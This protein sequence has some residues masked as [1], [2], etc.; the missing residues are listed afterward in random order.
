MYV[1]PEIEICSLN[2]NDII[3]TSDPGDLPINGPVDWG[4]YTGE[5]E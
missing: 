3:V 4:D 1:K 2:L 5:E